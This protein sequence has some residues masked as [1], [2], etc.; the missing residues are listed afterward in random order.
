MHFCPQPKPEPRVVGRHRRR[1]QADAEL[2]QAYA[3]VDLRDGSICWVTGRFTRLGGL[4]A[5]IRREH[6]HLKGRNVAPEW[7]TDPHRIITVCA[8]AHTLITHEFIVVEGVDARKPIL[9]HWASW[10]KPEQK[11]FRLKSKR[12]EAA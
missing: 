4:D 3:D 7:V 8:E 10:V 1:V 9:F 12:G 6:H 11:P 2:D 5:R